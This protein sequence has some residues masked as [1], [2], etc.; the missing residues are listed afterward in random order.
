LA[1]RQRFTAV[2]SDTPPTVSLFVWQCRYR[3]GSFELHSEKL[4]GSVPPQK[5]ARVE[6][7][8]RSWLVKTAAPI[9]DMIHVVLVD[10]NV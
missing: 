7:N 4:A 1:V 5:G 10:A 3:D 9:R 8:G 6:I 2:L